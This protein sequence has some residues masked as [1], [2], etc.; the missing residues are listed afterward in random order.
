MRVFSILGALLLMVLATV[1]LSCK[2]GS[3]TTEIIQPAVTTETIYYDVVAGY[4]L[5]GNRGTIDSASSH[6]LRPTW[7]VG[8][9]LATNLPADQ[10]KTFEIPV[11][12][13][14]GELAI[15]YYTD[16]ALR[17]T[18]GAVSWRQL[19][20]EQAAGRPVL[21]YLTEVGTFADAVNYSYNGSEELTGAVVGW[22][23]GLPFD[24]KIPLRNRVDATPQGLGEV[25]AR[26]LN[27]ALSGGFIQR[28]ITIHEKSD[29]WLVAGVLAIA[30]VV[31]GVAEVAMP[32]V[33]PGEENNSWIIFRDKGGNSDTHVTPPPTVTLA[34][35]G[36]SE[37][38]AG[39]A[40]TVQV[41]SNCPLG[42]TATW[43]GGGS[44]SGSG[45]G[46]VTI[47][48][49][50]SN[51][52]VSVA[53]GCGHMRSLTV[54][55]KAVPP[56]NQ[57]PVASLA[58]SPREGVAPLTVHV[59][60]SASHDPDGTIVEYRWYFYGGGGTFVGGNIPAMDHV[61]D[62]PGPYSIWLVVVD[63]D[64]ATDWTDSGIT[65]TVNE[66]P[67]VNQSPTAALTASPTSGTGSVNVTLDASASHDPDGTI[68]KY[69]W[70]FEGD[71]TYNT[72]T[73]TPVITH[74]YGV[75]TY[76]PRVRVTDDDGAMDTATAANAIVVEAAEVYEAFITPRNPVIEAPDEATFSAV[77]L[78]SHGVDVTPPGAIITFSCDESPGSIDPHDGVFYSILSGTGTF[79]VWAHINTG[80]GTYLD[81][82]VIT[83]N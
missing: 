47:T 70:D 19:D 39:S 37:A 72:T 80:S 8:G 64:G 69:E 32:V 79:T 48:M 31:A 30:G 12:N 40:V 9:T 3:T 55:L 22:I 59:D 71:G 27:I 68:I 5:A 54:H 51:L 10:G 23:P 49:P 35:S 6:I 14:V 52:F 58:A 82:T 4:K 1:L 75:G 83:V 20:R 41:A 16:F 7:N 11:K 24:I 50:S 2:G 61:Y 34:I 57:P 25:A 21:A 17:D 15:G 67:P 66:P 53:D 44:D 74:A 73:T 42:W 33:C 28:T 45:N 56:V 81:S 77:L 76:T 60:G 38:T 62:T 13:K 78:D 29:N 65:I 36:P 46:S 18:K 26:L 63:D 43:S